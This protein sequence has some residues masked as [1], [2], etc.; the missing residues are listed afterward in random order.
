MGEELPMLTL[1]SS[2]RNISRG[3]VR[4]P[5]FITRAFNRR[6]SKSVMADVRT[7]YTHPDHI[8]KSAS[9]RC[10]TRLG[11]SVAA[12]RRRFY[13]CSSTYRWP[14]RAINAR[15]ARESAYVV[16]VR[17]QDP[18][19]GRRRIGTRCRA[20]AGNRVDWCLEIT[21]RRRIRHPRH[22]PSHQI[23]PGRS[24]GSRGRGEFTT[25]LC[26]GDARR[27]LTG[28]YNGAWRHA[29]APNFTLLRDEGCPAARG[30]RFPLV[31][32]RYTDELI[33][34]N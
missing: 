26:S 8:R 27:E 13:P 3:S 10:I 31:V 21:A 18:L 4:R 16:K 14:S 33:A 9:E 7:D 17:R 2:K 22:S 20:W 29:S 28:R 19:S 6:D 12:I 32:L 25:R 34:W 5:R 15:Y 11:E 1:A 30:K 23:R 24:R